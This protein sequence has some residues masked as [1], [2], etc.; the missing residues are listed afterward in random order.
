M[1]P[2]GVIGMS[3]EWFVLRWFALDQGEFLMSG[4]VDVYR[5]KELFTVSCLTE[6]TKF[7]FEI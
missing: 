6:F 1:A 4:V 2:V 5:K 7:V 3:S